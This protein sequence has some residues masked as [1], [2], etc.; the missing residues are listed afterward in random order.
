MIEFQDPTLLPDGVSVTL[1]GPDWRAPIR[2][3][4]TDIKL[5]LNGDALTAMA[6]IAGMKSGEALDLPLPI[7]PRLQGSLRTLQD[8]LTSWYPDLHRIS[9][10]ARE[11]Q[12]AEPSPTG[13]GVACFFSGGV[14]S[15]YSVLKHKPLLTHLIFVHGLDVALTDAS[16]HNEVTQHLRRAAQA[17]ELPL[18]EVRT[19]L[20]QFSDARELRWGELYHGAALATVSLLLQADF[21]RV[22]VAA[23]NAYS[24]LHPWGSHPLLDGLWST[25]RTEI[26]HDGSE[27]DRAEK[28]A[29]ICQSE[30]ALR[31]LRVCWE[32]RSDRYNCGEC[33]KCLLTIAT[34]SM[35]GA[36]QRC[37]TL[38]DE[39]DLEG[40]RDSRITS[41]NHLARF[42]EV[43]RFA[44]THGHEQIAAV[45]RDI[46]RRSD[47]RRV[48]FPSGWPAQWFRA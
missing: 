39:L 41:R 16:L 6:L 19:N 35:A 11:Q 47:L 4:S 2:F 31:H 14:D 42:A 1:S 34:L 25:E 9:V 23:S 36:L 12:A 15:F 33:S 45:I 21:R 48:T 22:I 18:I 37:Q 28:I 38:P 32:N 8:I 43:L 13:E 10:K 46:V 20:R 24:D 29:R 44:E 5:S 3:R 40:L 26:R 30:I 27:L 7:S 17:L